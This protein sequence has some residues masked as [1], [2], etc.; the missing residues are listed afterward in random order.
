MKEYL[1]IDGYNVIYYSAQVRGLSDFDL[2]D[3]RES[4][5]HAAADYSGYTGCDL[6]VVF[7]AY[8]REEG[9]ERVEKRAGINIVF[10]PRD[11]TADAYI[12]RFVYDMTGS[13]QRSRRTERDL[14]TVVTSDNTLQQVIL[15]CGATRMSSREFLSEM[16]RVKAESAKAKARTVKPD[17]HRIADTMMPDL[18][19][20]LDAM[21]KAD[22]DPNAVSPA[23]KKE[24]TKPKKAPKA[25]P[26]P[27][28]HPQP[29][30]PAKAQNKKDDAGKAKKK[31]AVK[32]KRKT[33]QSKNKGPDKVSEKKLKLIKRHKMTYE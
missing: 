27:E 28:R 26:L 8:N 14:I 30:P 33:R 3:E 32:K 9:D 23:V 11:T 10:T 7:D 25:L 12:E 31:T 18:H 19:E 16:K 4:L 20:T 29:A 17:H 21:R 1:I 15:A 6:T 24:K 22:Y 2:E 5:I 13:M